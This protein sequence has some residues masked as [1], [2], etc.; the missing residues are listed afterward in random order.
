M[1]KKYFSY[2]D[3]RKEIDASQSFIDSLYEDIA[4]ESKRIRC[5]NL[6]YECMSDWEYPLI[7]RDIVM[8]SIELSKFAS[9]LCT[10]PEEYRSIFHNIVKKH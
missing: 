10:S 6:I 1:K 9:T 2:E 3:I 8:S 7:D 5:L 4:R